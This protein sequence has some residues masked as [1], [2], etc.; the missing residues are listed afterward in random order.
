MLNKSPLVSIILPAYNAEK[1]IFEAIK[2]VVGQSYSKWELLIV[3]DGSEDATEEIVWKFND[4]RIRYFTQSN[5]GVS[6]ARNVGLANMRGDYFCFLD[7]DDVMP[8]TSLISRLKVF[9]ENPE[10]AFVG[11]AQVQKDERLFK[12]LKVQ[13][14]NYRGKP[15]KGLIRMEQGCFINCGTWLIKKNKSRSYSFFDEWTH[16]EDLAFFLTIADDGKLDFTPEVVQIYRRSGGSAMSDLDGLQSGYRSFFQEVSRQEEVK[17]FE[18]LFLKWKIL[19]IMF[20]SF[21][22]DGKNI[23]KACKS[24]WVNLWL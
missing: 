6:A 23:R 24:L 4:K 16:S 21:L 9:E 17:K 14:P 15:K 13:K 19:K 11:G 22:F 18:R 7:A 10:L 20:L 8:Y 12:T 3:N 2:S 5:H 1:Y